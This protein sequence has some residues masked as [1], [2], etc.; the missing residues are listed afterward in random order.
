M[1]SLIFLFGSLPR[2]RP[3]DEF[4]EILMFE[5]W[6]EATAP[7]APGLL[8]QSGRCRPE[9]V[10]ILSSLISMN[11]VFSSIRLRTN[12]AMFFQGCFHKQNILECRRNEK[13]LYPINSI[14]A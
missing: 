3:P 9:N 13:P 10:F 5:F 11:G 12:P 6:R 4:T 8:Y 14:S 1:W 2:R 7:S